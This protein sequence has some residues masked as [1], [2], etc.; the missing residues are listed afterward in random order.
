MSIFAILPNWRCKTIARVKHRR[1][2]L[3]K[4]L[5]NAL[6]LF[7]R[8]IPARG[9]KIF[10][11]NRA[12]RGPGERAERAACHVSFCKGLPR[13]NAQVIKYRYVIILFNC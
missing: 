12:E 7:N 3:H 6:L 5:H 10:K 1:H 11:T 2:A 8:I 13:D 4:R 9:F